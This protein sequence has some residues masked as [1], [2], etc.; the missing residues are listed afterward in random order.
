LDF[1]HG[2]RHRLFAV[3]QNA[4]NVFGDGFAEA[5]FLL[6]G[7]AGPQLNHHMRHDYLLLFRLWLLMFWMRAE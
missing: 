2:D 6:L 4:H 3:V 7:F 5:S 1:F